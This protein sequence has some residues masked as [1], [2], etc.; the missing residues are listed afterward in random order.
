MVCCAIA[1]LSKSQLTE[2][3]LS[4][5]E[6]PSFPRFVGLLARCM[7]KISNK[8]ISSLTTVAHYKVHRCAGEPEGFAD[9]VLYISLVGKVH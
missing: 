5:M 6:K 1:Q 9:F 7:V 8:F 4:K 2:K 3:P